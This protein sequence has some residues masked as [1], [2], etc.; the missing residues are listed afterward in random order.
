MENNKYK[1]YDKSILDELYEQAKPIQ[2][3]G[4]DEFLK[5]P[6]NKEYEEY[7]KT[8]E[9]VSY[10]KLKETVEAEKLKEELPTYYDKVATVI[11]KELPK[12]LTDEEKL[13]EF[14]KL[15]V[16]FDE[17]KYLKSSYN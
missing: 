7:Q 15:R 6:V 5:L 8:Q 9:P 14:E 13:K 17:N 11:L 3:L 4:I 2:C 12:D 16:T 1:L 10:R